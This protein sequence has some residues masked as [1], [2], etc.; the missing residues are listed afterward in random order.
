VID[1]RLGRSAQVFSGSTRLG[2]GAVVGGD[3]KYWGENRAKIAQGA[4][5]R[6]TVTH[7]RGGGAGFLSGAQLPVGAFSLLVWIRTLIGVLALGLLFVWL[8]PAFARRSS[9]TLAARPGGSVG[10]GI[11][12]LIGIPILAVLIFIAGLFVGGWWLSLMMLAVYWIAI[13]LSIVV[14]GLFIGRWFLARTGGNTASLPL[15]MAIGVALLLVVSIV[16]IVGGIIMFVSLLLGLGALLL[17]GFRS[18]QRSAREPVR[19]AA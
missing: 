17:A 14:T 4:V 2:S 16:P 12:A 9:D 5:V 19:N 6:G 8:A 15:A 13:V 10:W 1:G 3:L 11:A 18:S 7:E